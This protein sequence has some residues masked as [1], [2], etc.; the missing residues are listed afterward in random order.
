MDDSMESKH[1][2]NKTIGAIAFVAAMAVRSAASAEDH[3]IKAVIT[4]WMPTVT[5]AKPGDR[6]IFRNMTGHDT[7]SM[8]GMIPEGAKPWKS[9]LGQEN[10]AV[11]VDKPGVYICTPHMS[12]GMVGAVV[13]GD[14]R[15][16]ANL[17]QVEANVKNVKVGRNMVQRA[18]R[19]MNKALAKEQQAKAAK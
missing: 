9:Q 16:P 8:E 1:M 10:F 18:I 13:G 7:E 5:F 3:I 14:Q 2:N 19:I 6:L 15:P 17:A 11:T 12:T 4:T